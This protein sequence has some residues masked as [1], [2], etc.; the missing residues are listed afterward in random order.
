M[1]DQPAPAGADVEQVLSGAQVELAADEVELRD[2]CRP[3]GCPRSGRLAF[4][5]FEGHLSAFVER[6]DEGGSSAKNETTI[7]A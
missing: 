5:R 4:P 6:L 1:A 7:P 3:A 2:L